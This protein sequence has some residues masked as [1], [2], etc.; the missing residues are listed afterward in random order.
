MAET[1]TI[2]VFILRRAVFS[3]RLSAS[4]STFSHGP[5]ASARVPDPLQ[6]VRTVPACLPACLPA[7][8][9]VSSDRSPGAIH[10]VET[11]ATDVHSR[12][13]AGS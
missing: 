2:G 8:A 5:P 7:A 10:T 6:S 11:E 12:T 3:M 9:C 13:S 1:F 4:G